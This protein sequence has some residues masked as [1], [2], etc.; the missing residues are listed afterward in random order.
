MPVEG[1]DILLDV[2]R[3]VSRS[4]TARQPTGLDRVCYAYLD[5]Y[6]TRALAVVQH[7]GVVRVLRARQSERLFELLTGPTQ[8]FR[9]KLARFTLPAITRAVPEARLE[10]MAYLNTSH[11][12][13]DLDTHFAWVRRSG[14]RAVYFIHDLIP[15]LHP[16]FTRPH[17]VRR[18]L[19]RLRGALGNGAGVIV[20]SNAV[21]ADLAAFAACDARDVPPMLMAP[22]AGEN[23]AGAPSRGVEAEPFFLC[24]GTIEPRKN[25]RLLLNGWRDLAGRMGAATPRLLVV[26]QPGPLTGDILADLATD[27][28]LA[29]RVEWRES[30]EDAELASLMA[31][32]RALL[33]PSLAEGF[34]LPLVEALQMGTP[35]IASD[36]QIFREISRGAATLV[37]PRD[38]ARWV[39][40]IAAHAIGPRRASGRF[41]A[42]TWQRHFDEVDSWLASSAL[43]SGAPCESSLAA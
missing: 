9:R 37:D 27:P 8:G 11:T 3:L 42:P 32:A 10:G 17:A 19:G 36:T 28:V 34:G 23:F 5:H 4:W 43:K 26:G 40:E 18:H 38:R 12:D 29:A 21:A 7:R 16:E 2:T 31:G 13:F 41:E 25:H 35:V 30:C 24:L 20:S 22:I 1:R 14:V 15:V 39:A 6:R 33:M